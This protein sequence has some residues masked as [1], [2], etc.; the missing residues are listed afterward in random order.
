MAG[1]VYIIKIMVIMGDDGIW[2]TDFLAGG[3]A[4]RVCRV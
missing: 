4:E 3:G 2:I 1:F